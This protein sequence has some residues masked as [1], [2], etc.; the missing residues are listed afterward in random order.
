MVPE[1]TGNR[2]LLKFG[3]AAPGEMNAGLGVAAIESAGDGAEAEL[4]AI[5]IVEGDMAS[6]KE[7]D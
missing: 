3:A 4:A 1:F 5:L 6:A 2:V 7:A